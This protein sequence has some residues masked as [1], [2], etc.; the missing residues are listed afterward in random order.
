M[1]T[2][3]LFLNN[4]IYLY[5]NTECNLYGGQ[6]QGLNSLLLKQDKNKY[7]IGI[8]KSYFKT[9]S[10]VLLFTTLKHSLVT[11]HKHVELFSCFSVK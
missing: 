6:V 7:S 11:F 10:F 2:A 1:V 4:R 8:S 3:V 5:T 9:E